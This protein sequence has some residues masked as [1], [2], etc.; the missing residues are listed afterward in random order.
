VKNRICFKQGRNDGSPMRKKVNYV[1]SAKFQE[2]L[3]DTLEQYERRGHFIRIYPAKGT[4]YYDIFFQPAKIVNKTLYRVL[5]SEN[6]GKKTP[7]VENLPALVENKS[8]NRR[9]FQKSKQYNDE[10]TPKPEKIVL[11][12]DDIL[13]EYISRIW[14]AIR[15]LREEKLKSN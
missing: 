15:S 4:D 6:S 14:H 10:N 9:T 8:P 7:I 13:I 2:H 12:A 1:Q 11:T 3:R 5:F